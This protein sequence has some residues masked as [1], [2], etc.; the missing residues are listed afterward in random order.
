MSKIT[1]TMSSMSNTVSIVESN[2]LSPVNQASVM[3]GIRSGMASSNLHDIAAM[4][5]D[6]NNGGFLIGESK[7]GGPQSVGP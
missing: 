3:Q 4:S 2:F 5:N 6:Y 1:S 7:W